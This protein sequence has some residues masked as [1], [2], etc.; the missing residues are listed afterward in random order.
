MNMT[1]SIVYVDGVG[2]SYTV[3]YN[4]AEGSTSAHLHYHGLTPM[5]SSSGEYDGGPD[6]SKEITLAQWEELKR[7]AEKLAAQTSVHQKYR[8]KGTSIIRL[9][10]KGSAEERSFYARGKPVTEFEKFVEQL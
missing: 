4:P 9:K 5:E 6:V 3:T 2:N 8:M 10:V 1:E 7:K